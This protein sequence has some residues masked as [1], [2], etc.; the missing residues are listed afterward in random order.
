MN[1]L[2]RHALISF[3]A[4]QV[5]LDS[6]ELRKFGARI[7][8][9]SQPFRALAIM[10]SRPGEVVTREELQH[11]IWGTNT[12][13]D[14]ER[15]LASAINKLREALG[16]AAESPRYIE[17]LAKRGYRF[18]AP[19]TTESPVTIETAQFAPAETFPVSVRIANLNTEQ[20]DIKP[21]AADISLSPAPPLS[22]GDLAPAHTFPIRRPTVVLL[23]L[24]CGFLGVAVLMAFLSTRTPHIVRPPRIVQLTQSNEVYAGLPSF[25]NLPILVTDGLRVYTSTLSGGR[26]QISSIELSGARTLPVSVPDEVSPVTIADISPDGSKLLLRSSRSRESEQPLWIVPTSGSTAVRIGDVLAHDAT[27]MPGGKNLLYAAGDELGVVQLDT[28]VTTIL[29]KLPGRAFWPRWSRDGRFLR[30]TLVDPITHASNLWEFEASTH[31]LHRLQFPQLG[32]LALCCGSWTADGKTYVFEASSPHESNIWALG[33]G[34]HPTI[35]EL[36]N[37][38]LRYFS[39][40]PSRDSQTIYFIGLEQPA[41]TRLYDRKLQSFIPAPSYLADAQRVAYSRNGDWVAWTDRDSRLWRA[42]S[43]D[44]SERFQLTPNDMEVFLAQWSPDGTRLVLMA[45]RPGETWQ[46]YVVS[47]EG[48]VTR[49][50]LA[51]KR[52]LADPSWSPDGR[53]LVLGREAEMMGKENGPHDLEYLDLASGGVQKLRGSENLFSPRWSPDGRWIIAL[54]LDQTQL[55]LYDVA[56]Q[57]WKTLFS[58]GAADP[59]WSSDSKSLYFHAFAEP[60]S[61][62]IRISIE[63]GSYERV[64]DLTKLGIPAGDNYFFSGVTPTGSPLIKPRIGSGNLYSVAIPQSR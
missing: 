28:G 6:G 8:L 34:A 53:R 29:T 3:G 13:V 49:S 2:Q 1:T 24:G 20:P 16:D 51:D 42:R 64:A 43:A 14:F 17:T 21:L 19:V 26:A 45:R 55:V 15:G 52:N 48:G 61:P 4:F 10:L 33:T 39:P 50:L 23:T 22:H 36:T 18:I 40:L 7:K 54:S 31:H 46:I 12:S 30:F 9:Q 35:T 59:I 5:D 38:P 27:W 37:G 60:G 11:E 56:S 41:A 25:E 63:D 62:I 58:G 57:N 32:T 47:A 44:G